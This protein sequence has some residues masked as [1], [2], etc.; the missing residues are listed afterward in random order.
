MWQEFSQA[1]Y[2]DLMEGWKV[3][4]VRC[5]EG[6]QGWGLFRAVKK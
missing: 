5:R 1:D 6:E 3:K 4:V 2:D